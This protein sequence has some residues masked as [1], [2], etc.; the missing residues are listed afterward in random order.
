[1]YECVKNNIFYCLVGFIWDDGFLFDM[2]MN[3]VWVQSCYSEL[4]QGVDMILMLF[5]ML[6]FIGVGN[7]IFF[8]VKM[9]CVDI[10]FVVVIKLSDCGLV[11]FVGVVID[12]GLFFSFLV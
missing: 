12:V 11:E 7:M 4:I 9:V 6:Y 1:M 5:S 10:N 8:G 3:L 2:E